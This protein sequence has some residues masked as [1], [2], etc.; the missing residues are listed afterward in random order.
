MHRRSV[1]SVL[2]ST[3]LF[4][5]SAACGDSSTTTP[6]APSTPQVTETFPGEINV[7][8]ALTFP[9][10]IS[11]G[12]F[13]TATLT[14]VGPDS[15]TL[16]GF[17][18]GTLNNSVCTVTGQGLFLDKAPQGATIVASVSAPGT[19]CLRVYDAGTITAP[20]TFSIDVAHP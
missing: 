12:G 19:L 8:G 2:L 6:I 14:A 7:N 13:V 20:T 18:I 9:F 15:T 4:A 5:S 16:I 11:A 1:L 10:T 3:A 17:S